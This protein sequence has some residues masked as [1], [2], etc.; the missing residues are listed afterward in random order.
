MRLLLW[1]AGF[2]IDVERR[3]EGAVFVGVVVWLVASNASSPPL[4][5]VDMNRN[6]IDPPS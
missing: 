6:R 3:A 5:L 1:S 2:A 4:A